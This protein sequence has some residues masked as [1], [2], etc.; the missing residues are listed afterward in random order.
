MA[1]KASRPRPANHAHGSLA[2]PGEAFPRHGVAM[3]PLS[4]V[5]FTNKAGTWLAPC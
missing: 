4:T 1:E 5:G 2:L 3:F